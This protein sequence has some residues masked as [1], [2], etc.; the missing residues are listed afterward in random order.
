MAI[1]LTGINNR[2][3][4]YSQHYLLALLEG[5]LKDLIA[6]W[7][8]VAGD[9]PDSEAHRP[10]PARIRSLAVTYFRLFNRWERLRDPVARL[11]AQTEWLHDF[12]ATLD[13]QPGTTWRTLAKGGIRIP[14]LASVDKSSGAPLLWM[15]PVLP[16]ADEPSADPLSLGI[17][18]AQYAADPSR[19][20]PQESGKP[21]DPE[22]TWEEIV[23]RHIF[24]L[25]E[26]PRWILLVSF[27]QVYLIDRTKWPE[28]RYLAFDLREIFNRREESTIRATTALLHRG[29]ICPAEGFALLDTLDEN[30]HRHAFS[31]SEDLKD[32]MRECVELLGNE[33]VHYMRDVLHEKVFSTPDD[34]LARELTRGCLRYLYRLLFIHYL[35][36]RPDLGYLPV[37]SEEYL[38]GYSLESLRDLEEVELLTERDRDGYFFDRSIRMLF[39][40]I[41]QGHPQDAQ[42]HLTS[43]IRDDFRIAPLKSHLFDPA[44]ALLIDRVRF[45]NSVLQAVIRCLSLGKHGR[46]RNARA[47]RISYAQLGI[48]QLGAV[49]EN[50]LAYTGFFAKT[51]LFEVKPADEDYNPLVHAY[52]VNEEDLAQYQDEERVYEKGAGNPERGTGDGNQD[53]DNTAPRRLLRHE[54][55][56]FIYRLAGRSRE[57]SASY[58]TPESLTKCLVKYALKELLPGKTADEILNLTV[59][60]MA[61]GSAAFL[62]EAIDQLAE[63]YL[64]LKQKETEQILSHEDYPREKQRVKMRLADNN[65]FGVDLNPTAIELAEISL[66]L[67]TIYQGANVPW[68]GMQLANGNSLIGARR[69]TFP[70][71]LLAEEDR[72]GGDKA[73]WTQAVPDQVPWLAESGHTTASRGFPKRPRDTVYHWLVPDLGMSVYNDK[74]IKDLKRTEIAAINTWRKAFCRAFTPADLKTLHALS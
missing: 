44:N 39:R 51:D 22:T 57:K 60:E 41:F 62:N 28:R 13:Y 35:E 67:N 18:P 56:D 15:L 14:L 37:K 9:H 25:D 70:A 1:N 4:Y 21:P 45:R 7:D 31:V 73:R 55:G 5:D 17:N 24:S 63:E 71:S 47:G 2:N 52:F 53:L 3:E 72:K 54:K 23:T 30:S 10:P 33:V 6:R 50:L 66:W 38:E 42:A 32:A 20:N 69:Q 68:F 19:D 61:A 43:S 58:Y 27:G 26:P 11:A 29:S 74:I 46:G 48:N 36:A 49:Y 12:L 40:L 8:Q 64:R 16:P 59:C 34:T 65:V